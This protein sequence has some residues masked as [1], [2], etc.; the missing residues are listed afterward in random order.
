MAVPLAGVALVVSVCLLGAG[1]TLA[2]AATAVAARAVTTRVRNRAAERANRAAT[3]E[4]LRA[5]AAE[6]RTGSLGGAAFS[7]AVEAA[8]EPLRSLL[9][10]AAAVAGR[11]DATDVA[12]AVAKAAAASRGSSRRGSDGLDRLVACWR[13]AARSGATLAPA[14]DRVADS[15]QDDVELRRA[16]AA[17]LAGPRATVRLLAGLPL[18]GLLLATAIGARPLAFL[19]GSRAGICC[20]GAAGLL[21]AAG[22]GWARRISRRAQHPTG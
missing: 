7:A 10:P 5:V 6:L 18:V 15:L 4:L 9:R 12:D 11:G 20:L 21:D 17:A 3:I 22:V 14:I 2:L 8:S 19:L 1:P 16:L 13:V